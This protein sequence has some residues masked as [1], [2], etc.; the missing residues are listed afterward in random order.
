MNNYR[1][2]LALT[3]A[4]TIIIVMIVAVHSFASEEISGSIV[5]SKIAGQERFM[6]TT[7]DGAE[8]LPPSFL[9]LKALKTNNEIRVVG[10]TASTSSPKIPVPMYMGFDSVREFSAIENLTLIIDLHQGKN[11]SKLSGGEVAC[12]EDNVCMI[13]TKTGERIIV[14]S[15]VNGNFLEKMQAFISVGG[16]LS[17]TSSCD[18]RDESC[19][20]H[21]IK[22]LEQIVVE[23]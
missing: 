14:P 13:L 20:T 7:P 8:I 21:E 19:P 5:A 9:N 12:F 17:L 4:F 10:T 23:F 2:F 11:P 16:K 15:S 18:R 1:I 6:F 3:R 22:K